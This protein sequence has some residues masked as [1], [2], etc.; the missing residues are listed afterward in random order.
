M[1]KFIYLFVTILCTL[2]FANYKY[3]TG[4]RVIAYQEEEKPV[5]AIAS[6][7]MMIAIAALWALYFVIF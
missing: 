2:Y 6:F 4:I 1:V 5:A 7:V 3:S